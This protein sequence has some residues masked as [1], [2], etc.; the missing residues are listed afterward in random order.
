MTNVNNVYLISLSVEAQ[1]S[2]IPRAEGASSSGQTGVP[3]L[4][5]S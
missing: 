1:I 2:P 3:L 5:N 4:S